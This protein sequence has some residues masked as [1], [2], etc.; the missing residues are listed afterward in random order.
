M[1]R[2]LRAKRILISKPV[3]DRS[4]IEPHRE[5]LRVRLDS[6]TG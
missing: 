1:R 5:Q 3:E 2:K 4:F 6:E